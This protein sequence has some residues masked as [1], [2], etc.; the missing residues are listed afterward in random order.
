MMFQVVASKVSSRRFGLAVAS[1]VGGGV[2]YH[3]YSNE[4]NQTALLQLQSVRAVNEH[5]SLVFPTMEALLRAGRLAKT[6]ATMAVDYQL[7]FMTK[8][9]PDSFLSKMYSSEEECERQKAERLIYKLQ[10]E[11]DQAQAAYVEGSN[12]DDSANKETI[13]DDNTAEQNNDTKSKN[14]K[15][16]ML[17]IANQLADAEDVYDKSG[18]S[19]SVHERNANRLLQLFR[20]NAGVYIKVGQHLANLDLLLPQEYLTRLSS[21]FDDAPVSSYEDVCTVVKEDLGSCPH[22]LFDDFSRDPI[23]SASLAQVHTA[24]CKE[25]GRKLAI[26]I[27]HKGLRETSKG[28]LFAVTAVVRIA[29]N[30]FDEFNLGW[31]CDEMTPQLPKE[32]DFTNEG[33]NAEAASAHLQKTGLDCVVP[34]VLWRST[35]GEQCLTSERVLTMEF[36]SG[37][38]ATDVERIDSIGICRR[39]TAKL[40]SSVFNAQ[41]FE[42]GLVH[43]DPHQSNVLL[44]E[45]PK[46]KGKPQIVLVD[47]GLYKRLDPEFQESYA[48]LWTGIVMADISAIKGACESLGVDKMYPLLAAM[49]TSRPFDEVIERS[50]TGSLDASPASGGGDKAVIKLYAQRYLK[51]IIDMLDIVPRQMLLIF[52]MNDCLRHVDYAL[53]SPS[54]NLVIAGKYASKR[55]LDSDI[56][57]PKGTM[58]G[59][60]KSWIQYANVLFRI[61]S[62]EMWH[63]L[64]NLNLL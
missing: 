37:F 41:I 64:S 20:A 26:K 6:A 45:H 31:I 23:A 29:E 39:E 1:C 33:N 40:I 32:L 52:K 59:F 55:V 13:N 14:A 18:N 58:L 27:Q 62:Y 12:D 30:L 2:G 22:E 21:L 54:N 15:Q 5:L 8:K 4:G 57:H 43:C 47:H 11:L 53:G 17:S 10:E 16:H 35:T 60:F 9:H 51:E 48:R 38:P 49:L 28:D 19:S 61:N 56:S 3:V 25:T 46:K 24:R 34:H 50:Q 42:N 63:W 36:E 7:Y 44:R